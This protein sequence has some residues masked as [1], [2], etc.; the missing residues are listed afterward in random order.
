MSSRVL[1]VRFPTL[2]TSLTTL[3]AHTLQE[4]RLEVSAVEKAGSQPWWMWLRREAF[5]RLRK[6]DGHSGE[7]WGLDSWV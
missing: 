4:S 7:S 6:V 5:R 1:G 2:P 3:P